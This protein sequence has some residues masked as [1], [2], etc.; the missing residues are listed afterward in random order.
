VD[1]KVGVYIAPDRSWGGSFQYSV[2]LA[3]CLLKNLQGREG[4]LFHAHADVLGALSMVKNWSAVL[5]GRQTRDLAEQAMYAAVSAGSLAGLKYLGS[6]GFIRT[7]YDKVVRHRV[8]LMFCTTPE[9]ICLRLKMPYVVTIH[10]LQHRLQPEFPEVSARG[11]WLHR[12]FVYRHSV[13]RAAGVLVD[14]EAGKEDVLR[15]YRISPDRIHILPLRPSTSVVVRPERAQVDEVKRRYSLPERYLFYPAKFWAHK[16]HLGVLDALRILRERENLRMT[17]V[18][19]GS[20]GGVHK[21]LQAFVARHSR[22]DQVRFLG[23]VPEP[24]L[25]PLYAGAWALVMP[26]FFGPSN[27]PV[28][29]AFQM[30]CPVITSDLRGIREQVGG[31]GLLVDPRRSETIA[32]ALLSLHRDEALRRSLIEKGRTR[33]SSWT[34]SDYT[35]ILLGV[36]E[37]LMP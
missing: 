6:A 4:V 14:S 27:T 5:V 7:A 30:G 35:N 1:K 28:W 12:E 2:N 18:F 19:S 16:N 20:P 31:A 8:G 9:E 17:A 32:D 3:S 36:V 34:E 23:Y 37:R 24:N 29:E 10:D 11:R 21:Q 15:F 33:M 26:T 13:E 25:A 22:A